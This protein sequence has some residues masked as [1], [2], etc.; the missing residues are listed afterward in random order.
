MSYIVIEDLKMHN[1]LI[2]V[3]VLI[4]I[5]YLI[6]NKI[7]TL[8]PS[9][10]ESNANTNAKDMYLNLNM[11]GLCAP[12]NGKDSKEDSKEDSVVLND[13]QK[14]IIKGCPPTKSLA[15]QLFDQKKL[16]NELKLQLEDKTQP[17]RYTNTDRYIIDNRLDSDFGIDSSHPQGDDKFT[18]GMRNNGKKSQEALYNRSLWTKN[19]L[20]PYLAE[21]LA[22]HENAGGWW[23]CDDLEA[24]M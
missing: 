14:E 13:C 2:Y 8:S 24:E 18:V 9:D 21:E 6:D 22:E 3:L 23:D 7:A 11:S 10:L 12:L 4:L 16:Y 19:S 5:Y 20:I 15:D 1:I 17:Y